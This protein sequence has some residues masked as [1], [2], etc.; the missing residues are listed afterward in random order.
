MKKSKRDKIEPYVLLENYMTE[1]AAWIALSDRAIWLYLELK[2]QFNFS[3]GGNNHLWLPYSKV[4]W[5]MSRGS[6]CQ[7]M[8]EL[9]RYGFIRIVE[10]G[11]LL[12]RPNI[13]ALSDT[14]RGV[15]KE[16]V[17]KEGQEAI[18]LGLA[19]KPCSRNNLENLQG[20]RRWER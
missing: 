20:K 9:C 17:D 1:T 5:R 18:R 12:K 15:S 13:Y 14:W 3:Q 7:K 2:K 11:G 19:K 8:E 4:A 16:I 6:Y 10:H